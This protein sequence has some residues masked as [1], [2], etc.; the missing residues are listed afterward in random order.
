M[1]HARRRPKRLPAKL[2]QIRN[3]LGVSQR[4]MVERL[5]VEIRANNISKYELNKNEPPIR[6]LLAYA[7]VA[8]VR[9]A[10]IVD[11]EMDLTL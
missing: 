9:L 2:R 5:G 8:K 6:V 3:A 4:E 7:R 10:E 11:D 1:G